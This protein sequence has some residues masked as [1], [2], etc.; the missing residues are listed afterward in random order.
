MST[1]IR[2]ASSPPVTASAGARDRDAI[3]VWNTASPVRTISANLLLRINSKK[4]SWRRVRLFI[5]TLC[6]PRFNDADFN[7]RDILSC[8][9]LTLDDSDQVPAGQ[10][11]FVP[12]EAEQPP[13]II[14][15]Q[16]APIIPHR[17]ISS[18]SDS[19]SSRA[20]CSSLSIPSKFR[21]IRSGDNLSNGSNKFR[22]GLLQRDNHCLITKSPTALVATHIVAFYCR[23]KLQDLPWP[24]RNKLEEIGVD[25]VRNGLLLLNSLAAAFDRSDI[26]FR[27]TNDSSLEVV[28]LDRD[29]DYID[30]ATADENHRYY[31]PYQIRIPGRESSPTPL[32]WGNQNKPDKTLIDFHF[33]NSVYFRMSGKA[34]VDDMY[35]DDVELH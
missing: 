24:V 9:T 29:W 8:V 22:E 30:G 13:L 17:V 12:N 21:R 33:A 35:D 26:S 20:E 11:A 28:S 32:D 15:F 6:G 1:D 31:I 25:D 27:Y 34:I 5:E 16:P 7:F 10:Y 3:L 4:K 18:S 23:E 19:D 14:S 2:E